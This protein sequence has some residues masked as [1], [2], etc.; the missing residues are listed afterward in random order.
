M[1]GACATID[2]D[3]ER[4]ISDCLKRCE[5]SGGRDVTVEHI[6][7]EQSQTWCEQRCQYCREKTTPPS[8]PPSAGPPTFTGNAK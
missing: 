5:Q 4:Q 7:P 6:T 2:E 1:L 8:A 3:C